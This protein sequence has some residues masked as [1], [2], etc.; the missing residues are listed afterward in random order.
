MKLV[1]R[2]ISVWG[3]IAVAAVFTVNGLVAFGL[4]TSTHI[5]FV[6]PIALK[7]VFFGIWLIV[8]GFS[9]PEV[10]SDLVRS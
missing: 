8:R 10:A 5:V 9:A 4:S 2:F 3:L 7:E 6:L 1:P